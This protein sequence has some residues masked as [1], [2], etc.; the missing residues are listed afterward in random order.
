MGYR[1][2]LDSD[3]QRLLNELCIRLGFCLP[4][5]SSRS[6]V[7]SPPAGVDAFTDAVLE[8]EGMG[9]M[10][11]TDIR[12]QVREVVDDHM[13]RWAHVDGGDTDG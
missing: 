12:R 3:V 9:D 6:L 1:D 8:A 2:D 11:Y 10:S 13:S 4:P 5:Q 7:E